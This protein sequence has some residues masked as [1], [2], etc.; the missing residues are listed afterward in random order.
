M[1]VVRLAL[2]GVFAFAG[3]QKLRDPLG[4]RRTMRALRLPAVPIL[5]V[6]LP[7][8]ELVTA[9]GLV[10]FP[11]VGGALALALLVIFIVL[12]ALDIAEGRD[13]PCGCFGPR[14]T[15]PISSTDVGRNVVLAVGAVL[16]M[17]S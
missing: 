9:A 7:A 11:A 3:V 13:T 5:A 17:V 16:V 4:T 8:A 10:F 6:A 14:S 1:L 15:K 2:A 12:M